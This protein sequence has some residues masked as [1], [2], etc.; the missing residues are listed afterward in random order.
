M[1][2]PARRALA[3]LVVTALVLG[4][5][6][7][8]LGQSEEDVRQAEAAWERS[9]SARREATTAARAAEGTLVAAVHRYEELTAELHAVSLELAAIIDDA[10]ERERVTASHRSEARRLTAMAYMAAAAGPGPGI[11]MAHDLGDLA[12]VAEIGER[13]ATRRTA[14]LTELEAASA[15]LAGRRELVD[16]A[17][18]RQTEVR[19]E[20]QALV[21]VLARAA[22]GARL[23]ET[24][25]VDDEAD[26]RTAYELAVAELEAALASVSPGALAWRPLV[27][28]YFPEEMTW[29][30]LQVLDCESRGDPTA[31]HEGSGATG[32]FQFLEGTWIFASAGAGFA[33]ADR[34]DPEANVAA[35][36]WLVARSKSLAHPR[37]AWGHWVCQPRRG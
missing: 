19:G 20:A 9:A 26:A 33:G 25:A 28:A 14:A 27:E 8:A 37:G 11:A 34:T 15:D 23:A 10:R 16:A 6:A 29:A 35:A 30:A 5:A 36:A 32:L 3:L 13:L 4:S 21:P 1:A 7:G 18:L 2:P 24:F 17:R 31:I 12:L 22:D